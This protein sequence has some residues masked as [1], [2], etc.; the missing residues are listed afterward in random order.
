MDA[1]AVRCIFFVPS[2][3]VPNSIL[4]DTAVRLARLFLA[5]A[6]L[7]AAASAAPTAAQ[8]PFT[9]KRLA[10]GSDPGTVAAALAE[11][12]F[13]PHS[14]FAPVKGDRLY[15]APNGVTAIASFAD[16]VL[17]GVSLLYIADAGRVQDFYDHWVQESTRT[18]GDPAERADDRVSW[19]SGETAFTLELSESD[20]GARY[21]LIQWT[22]PGFEEEVAR[23]RRG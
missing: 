20:S 10:W 18:L 15:E 19:R 2:Q 17:V 4:S 23:R 5:A 9:Y 22:G 8:A 13:A 14:Q 12:G 1:C 3:A 16:E 21:V 7:A 6:A 11:D